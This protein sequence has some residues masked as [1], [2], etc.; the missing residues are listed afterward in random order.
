MPNNNDIARDLTVIYLQNNF[1]VNLSPK[2]L[3]QKYKE[4]YKIFEDELKEPVPKVKLLDR[5]K[6][7]L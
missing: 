5:R 6:L 1:Y 7:G 3:V 4:T 2:E